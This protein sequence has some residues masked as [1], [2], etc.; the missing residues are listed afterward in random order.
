MSHNPTKGTAKLTKNGQIIGKEVEH[1]DLKKKPLSISANVF[2]EGASIT[3]PESDPSN[4]HY[5]GQC[6]F[7]RFSTK[8]IDEND[9]RTFKSPSG[10]G[11]EEV[12]GVAEKN[13]SN[14]GGDGKTNEV[15]F[16]I[17]AGSQQGNK[18]TFKMETSSTY[19]RWEEDKIT[20]GSNTVT[21]YPKNTFKA[22]DIAKMSHNPTKGT[23]KLTKNGVILGKEYEHAD[24]KKKP[25][26]ISANMF[27]EGAKVTIL[28]SDK[29]PTN[30]VEASV[31]SS[32]AS[33]TSSTSS[34]ASTKYET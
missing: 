26:S 20:Y 11:T 6:K 21:T 30:K 16:L 10:N 15:S 27:T 22:G 2:T 25:L 13:F 32:V 23:V 14:D 31:A 3:I 17:E 33:S 12:F 5:D 18:F 1:G 29:A 24:L 8:A 19:V 4:T 7:T 34:T 9:K 28:E